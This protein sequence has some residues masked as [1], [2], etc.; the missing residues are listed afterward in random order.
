VVLAGWG[1]F[2]RHLR[3]IFVFVIM[4]W[5]AVGSGC[6][7]QRDAA[8]SIHQASDCPKQ[9]VAKGAENTV[10]SGA[11]RS[12]MVDPRGGTEII[13]V[14]SDRGW[15]DYEVPTGRYGVKPGEL[16]RLDV[17]TGRVIGIVGK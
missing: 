9:F 12:P 6:M 14:R 5:V 17:A 10:A 15:G 11:A 7:T 16:L 13:L 1:M 8:A 2:M 4:V 3:R